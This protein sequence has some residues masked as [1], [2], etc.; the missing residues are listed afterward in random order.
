MKV[1]C[2][3]EGEYFGKVYEVCDI[4]YDIKYNTGH[5][6]AITDKKSPHIATY[7]PQK[8]YIPVQEFREKILNDILFK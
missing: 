6:R 1:V 2:I 3:K 4:E 8:F 7:L 5:Y